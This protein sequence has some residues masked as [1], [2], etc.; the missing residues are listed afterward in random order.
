MKRKRN[1]CLEN[2]CG[3][4]KALL[5]EASQFGSAGLTEKNK[6]ILRTYLS[7]HHVSKT[8][9]FCPLFILAT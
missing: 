2:D 6:V 5:V 3:L 1:L 9:L 8:S 4:G 7:L